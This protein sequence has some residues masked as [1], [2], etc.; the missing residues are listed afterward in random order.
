MVVY[1]APLR[2]HEQM[3]AI[4]CQL[5][6]LFEE[7]G[8]KLCWNKDNNFVNMLLQ[9]SQALQQVDCHSDGKENTLSKID[10]LT[11][12]RALSPTRTPV[13]KQL[14]ALKDNSKQALNTSYA[15]CCSNIQS[16][17][18]EE[19]FLDKWLTSGCTSSSLAFMMP[20]SLVHTAWHKWPLV[21]DQQGYASKWIKEYVG[22]DLICLDG[23][24]RY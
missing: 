17:L 7:R 14:T 4:N 21:C 1:L 19:H 13:K 11:G 10:S 23:R 12:E 5:V 22:E 2:P 18:V 16:L 8:I 15:A 3:E 9:A 6:P 24:D 20:S